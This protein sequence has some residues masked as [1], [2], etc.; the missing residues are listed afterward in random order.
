MSN[1]DGRGGFGDHPEHRADGRWS[2]E[3]SDRYWMGRFGRM[4]LSELAQWQTKSDDEITVA[5]KRALER[6]IE[7]LRDAA[8]SREAIPAHDLILDRTEGKPRIAI[9]NNIGAQGDTSLELIIKSDDDK[10][11]DNDNTE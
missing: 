2:P 6:T 10:D 7:S 5:Q 8:K 9:D 1:P 4:T 11:N 3:T